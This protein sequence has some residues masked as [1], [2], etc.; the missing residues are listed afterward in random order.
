[1]Y[2]GVLAE[3]VRLGT[4]GLWVFMAQRMPCWLLRAIGRLNPRWQL[5]GLATS[6]SLAA[7]YSLPRGERM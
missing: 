4:G 5:L 7:T 6:L 1:M 2:L 3:E